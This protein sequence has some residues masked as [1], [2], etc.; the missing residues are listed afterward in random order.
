MNKCFIK[1]A[2]SK[3][4]PGKGGFWSLDIKRLEESRRSKR[5]STLTVRKKKSLSNYP[6]NDKIIKK[7]YYQTTDNSNAKMTVSKKYEKKHNILSNI[8]ICGGTEVKRKSLSKNSTKHFDN[9]DFSEIIPNPTT[10]NVVDRTDEILP[11]QDASVIETVIDNEFIL[12]DKFISSN[13]QT[14]IF[15]DF[16]LTNLFNGDPDDLNWHDEGLQFFD[17]WFGDF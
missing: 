2:R 3:T 16:D 17:S 15:N 4:E 12:D 13:G 8:F 5:C 14:M 10:D 11:N 9:H 6:K 7:K 1:V